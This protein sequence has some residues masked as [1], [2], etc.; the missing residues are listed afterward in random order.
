MSRGK[1]TWARSQD[2]PMVRVQPSDKS[3]V[4]E[5][6]AKLAYEEYCRQFWKSQ[7]FEEI[8]ERGGFHTFELIALLADHIE[9]LKESNANH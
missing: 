6:I 4:P 5:G 2:E 1:W 9:Y 7:S 8:Q 3:V